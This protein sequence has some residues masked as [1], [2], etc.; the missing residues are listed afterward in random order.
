MSSS[1]VAQM[2][3]K[4]EAIAT[5]TT[6]FVGTA[7]LVGNTFT[8]TASIANVYYSWHVNAHSMVKG[9]G[10]DLAHRSYV[11]VKIYGNI[12][13]T[14]TGLSVVPVPSTVQCLFSSAYGGASDSD[15]VNTDFVWYDDISVTA[16]HTYAFK[17]WIEATVYDN[18]N[19]GGNSFAQIDMDG[20]YSATVNY[21]L[22]SW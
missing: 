9:N 10:V 12:V 19:S 16:G 20:S 22:A 4:T 8:P 21:E 17:T 11:V 15:Y 1:G 2:D 7:G 3:F 5:Q 13:D 6:Y 14:S 18:M